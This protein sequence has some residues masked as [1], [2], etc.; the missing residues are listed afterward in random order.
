[1]N[2][3]FDYIRSEKWIQIITETRAP[4]M[5]EVTEHIPSFQ[6][7]VDSVSTGGIS[8][9]QP[10]AMNTKLKARTSCSYL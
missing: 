5:K 7:Q 10:E 9:E 3:K 1:M 6:V 4:R 2:L 8:K